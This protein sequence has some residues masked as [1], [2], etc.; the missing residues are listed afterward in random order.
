M[1]AFPFK[2]CPSSGVSRN[3][4][5]TLYSTAPLHNFSLG[6]AAAVLDNP[7][8]AYLW[9]VR[10]LGLVIEMKNVRLCATSRMQIAHSHQG[11]YR[12]AITECLHCRVAVGDG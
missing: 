6:S 3:E 7:V 9:I 4:Q 11:R 2:Y 10:V 5:P 1:S 8:I 12:V